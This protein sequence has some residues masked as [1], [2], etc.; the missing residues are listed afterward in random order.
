MTERSGPPHGQR[1]NGSPHRVG[2]VV[3]IG[4]V[5]VVRKT[6]AIEQ[7]VDHPDRKLERMLHSDDP[8]V[9]RTKSAHEQHLRSVATVLDVLNRSGVE[10]RLVSTFNRNWAAW[11]DLVLTVGGDGTFLR[12]SHC[13]A[14]TPDSDGTPMFGVNSASGTSVGFFCA[15]SAEEFEPLFQQ[16]LAGQLRSRGLWRLQVSL[17]DKPLRDLALNDVLLAHRVPAET[18]RYTLSL[19]GVHQDQKSSGLWVATAAGSTAGIRAAGGKVQE[20]DSRALQYRVRELM[21]WAVRGEPLMGGFTS[22]GL[23]IVSRMSTGM[24]Y[25][26]GAHRRASF[27]F[28]DRIRF[29]PS[30]RP[31]PWIAPASLDEKR[32]AQLAAQ[33]AGKGIG[34]R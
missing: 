28:G 15:A 9:A 5:V 33:E 2:D 27:G 23:E 7:L 24:L 29:E 31:L 13:I 34:T 12:A 11:A 21:A 17:N 22:D 19:D 16:I 6:T 10:H 4:R 26:D 1:T 18:S 20:I 32:Q 14:A 25:L 3:R 8:L 30:P